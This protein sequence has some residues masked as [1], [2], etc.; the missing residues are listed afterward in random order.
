MNARSTLIVY[1]LTNIKT[2]FF[3]KKI[4]VTCLS[5]GESPV[6]ANG[7]WEQDNQAFE[8]FRGGGRHILFGCR[9]VEISLADSPHGSSPAK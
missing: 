1:I 6:A 8:D 5:R 3:Y 7:Y 4:F 2:T 9:F